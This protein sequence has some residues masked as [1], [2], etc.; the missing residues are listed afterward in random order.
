MYCAS[1]RVEDAQGG[2][3]LLEHLRLYPQRQRLDGL[4]LL[5]GYA[6]LGTF[7]AL[8]EG[9]PLPATLADHLHDLLICRQRL[10]GSASMLAYG[11]LAVRLLGEDHSSV[12]QALH[13]I[14]DTLRQ[15][16]LGYPAVPHRT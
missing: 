4:G 13:D 10:I 2:M 9:T 5:E 12:R 16:V 1:L 7:Y 8:R 3:V 6:Y 11:G 15:H 14:W